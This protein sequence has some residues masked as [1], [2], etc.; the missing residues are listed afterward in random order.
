VAFEVER[1]AECSQ[2]PR[3]EIAHLLGLFHAG[4]ENGELVA[5]EPGNDVL[6]A[7][8]GR[9]RAATLCSSTSPSEW[10]ACR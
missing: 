7:K 9:S 6:L 4:L 5:A 3:Q 10:R 8:L 2:Q 1:L